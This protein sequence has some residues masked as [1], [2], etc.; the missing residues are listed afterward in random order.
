MVVVAVKSTLCFAKGVL[1]ILSLGFLTAYKIIVVLSGKVEVG[2]PN[3]DWYEATC[4]MYWTDYYGFY[5]LPSF[6]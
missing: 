2:N 1:L 6:L 5:N 3:S 4:R